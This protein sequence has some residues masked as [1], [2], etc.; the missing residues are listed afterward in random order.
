MPRTT[1][2]YPNRKP[3]FRLVR[4]VGKKKVKSMQRPLSEKSFE[5]LE[6]EAFLPDGKMVYSE[7]FKIPGLDSLGYFVV[8]DSGIDNRHSFSLYGYSMGGPGGIPILV[9]RKN[10]WFVYASKSKD[11]PEG[12]PASET[13]YGAQVQLF[14]SKAKDILRDLIRENS[15]S[16]SKINPL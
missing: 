12:R 7:P 15:D 4:S 14:E 5:L 13:S 8:M 16:G 1:K 3:A 6:I 2:H 11:L 9:R 10:S